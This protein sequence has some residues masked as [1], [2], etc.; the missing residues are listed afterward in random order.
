MRI[1]I[2]SG[3]MTILHVGHLRLFKAS[4]EMFNDS[5]VIAG[6]N[7][8][9]AQIRKSGRVIVPWEQRAEMVAGIKYVDKVVGF[10]DDDNTAK[11]L[12]IDITKQYPNNKIYFVNG[13]DRTKKNVP[14]QP[15]C[16]ELNVEMLW[17]VGGDKIQSSSWLIN[18]GAND[19]HQ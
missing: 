9:A 4:K 6:L 12:I 7:S 11:S 1:L 10:N 5:Y 15:L 8:D 2:T 16:K 17:G 19:E 3:F 14:E 13:G 18:N